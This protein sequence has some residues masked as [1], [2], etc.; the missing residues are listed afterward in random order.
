VSHIEKETN[1]YNDNIINGN[2]SSSDYRSDSLD[3]DAVKRIDVSDATKCFMGTFVESGMAVTRV[4]ATGAN[5]VRYTQRFII[6]LNF[7][8]C[9]S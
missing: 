1:N 5:T 3:A 7:M 2:G 9:S 6:W 8:M 4:I